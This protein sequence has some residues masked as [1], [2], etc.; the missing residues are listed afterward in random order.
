MDAGE[1]TTV[2]KNVIETF[3]VLVTL[4]KQLRR[5]PPQDRRR[6]KKPRR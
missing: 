2:I 5:Q 4:V 3:A 1:A 6:R